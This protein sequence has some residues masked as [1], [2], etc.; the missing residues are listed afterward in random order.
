MR[1]REHVDDSEI[2]KLCEEVI[3]DHLIYARA[4]N[5]AK[6]FSERLNIKDIQGID[7]L[8]KRKEICDFISKKQIEE[9]FKSIKKYFPF[10]FE[11]SD[12]TE[13]KLI[14]D[15]FKQMFIDYVEQG[16]FQKAINTAK[17]FLEKNNFGFDPHVF[18]ILGY[19][20]F[21]NHNIKKFFNSERSSKLAEN[22]NEV[23]Y[24]RVK[25]HS[26]SLLHTLLLHYSSVLYFL[27]K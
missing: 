16:D 8:K 1:L 17:E 20:D 19:S 23:I 18:S 2:E 4:E 11:T 7:F 13:K 10:L 22:F 21:E 24:K 26:N 25:G 5:T 14:D 12:E 27:N 15:L 6:L 9:A 3:L